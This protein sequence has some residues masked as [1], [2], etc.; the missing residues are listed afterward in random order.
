M[1]AY[2]SAAEAEIREAVV[3]KIRM[4]RPGYRIIHEINARD[5]GNRI[6]VLA[7]GPAE[8]IAVEI[9]SEKDK[10][11]RLP[12]QI[13]AMRGAAHHTIA[14][15]HE[16]FLVPA[17]WAKGYKAVQAPKEAKGAT[18][19]AYP[20]AGAEAGRTYGC[21]AWDFPRQ[22]V[23]AM[24]PADAIHMLWRA[25]LHE[26]CNRLHVSLG[27]RPNMAQMV[28]ALR[29]NC[30]GSE[31]TKGICTMLRARKCIEADPEIVEV[32]AA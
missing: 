1:P 12:A 24:L 5:F 8:I 10:L 18:I 4:E 19:W 28:N 20:E 13:A 25:E 9:K 15:I 26:L 3:S 29:W 32:R 14:A 27:K 2:R 22:A 7:V 23:T 17:P 21:A 16:K 30:T 11:D 31:L 6:D